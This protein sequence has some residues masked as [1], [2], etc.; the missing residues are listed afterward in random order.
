M[1]H[2]ILNRI[3]CHLNKYQQLYKSVFKEFKEKNKYADM[4]PFKFNRVRLCHPDKII[5]NLIRTSSF[6]D[7]NR[8]PGMTL[9]RRAT[10]YQPISGISGRPTSTSFSI[11][12]LGMAAER[13]VGTDGGGTQEGSSSGGGQQSGTFGT[14]TDENN[15][16]D[17]VNASY[18]NSIMTKGSI[19]AASAPTQRTVCDFLQMI[20]ENQVS[21]VMKVCDFKVKGKE[22]CFKYLGKTKPAGA[23]WMKSID[24]L[25]SK[26]QN[27]PLPPPTNFLSENSNTLFTIECI[28]IKKKFGGDLII[29][30]MK[31]VRKV[32]RPQASDLMINRQNLSS[33]NMM[34]GTD[35]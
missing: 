1:E 32:L 13:H 5:T 25:Y 34:N 28:K 15:F 10:E 12:D 6:S 19:I 26:M 3:N 16:R 8:P 35:L 33:D 31:V 18:I 9:A 23:N 30:K 20:I 27:L 21:L 11:V 4:L 17:Y 14:D 2:G 29:R 22:Q 7:L 24:L